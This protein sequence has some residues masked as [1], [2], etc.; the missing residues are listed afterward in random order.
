MI[1]ESSRKVSLNQPTR[2]SLPTVLLAEK[3]RV[4]ERIRREWRTAIRLWVIRIT[5]E[6][7]YLSLFLLLR[8]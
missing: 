6:G 3:S 2:L 5:I 7:E 8:D 1:A 4:L